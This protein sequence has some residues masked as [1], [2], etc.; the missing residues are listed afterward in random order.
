MCSPRRCVA[1]W[2]PRR[3]ARTLRARRAMRRPTCF[4]DGQRCAG[5]LAPGAGR[6]PALRMRRG[7]RSGCTTCAPTWRGAA[8]AYTRRWPRR[9]STRHRARCSRTTSCARSTQ[10]PSSGTTG[11]GAAARSPTRSWSTSRG[12]RRRRWPA[13]TSGRRLS[14]C[15]PAPSS[16]P[17]QGG[18]GTSLRC[19]TA[20]SAPARH[21]GSQTPRTGVRETTWASSCS[22]APGVRTWRASSAWST[23]HACSARGMRRGCCSSP[24]ARTPCTLRTRTRCSPCGSGSGRTWRSSCWTTRS[25]TRTRRSARRSTC[26]CLR[27]PGTTPGGS[28][29]CA[30][31]RS[32]S[33][34]TGS[35]PRTAASACW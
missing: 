34:T 7:R 14:R 1:W 25:G 29:R 35:R 27:L 13:W 30:R 9:R 21:C 33:G 32:R 22:S 28:A 17:R 16:V 20:R 11:S 5:R 18:C 24:G 3:S 10:V 2:S 12:S 23:R 15:R 8:P 26:W 6:M 31:R 4:T 19:R